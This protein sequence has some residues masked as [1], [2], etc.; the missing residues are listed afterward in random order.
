MICYGEYRG[1]RELKLF[2]RYVKARIEEYNREETYRF[3]VTESL[4]F[5]PQGKV[6][7]KSYFELL[8]PQK[9]ETRSGKEV[10]EKVAEKLGTK[11]DWGR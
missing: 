10:S 7:N 1:K 8:K 2:L 3:F 11:I 6:I 9:I 5:A 4:R